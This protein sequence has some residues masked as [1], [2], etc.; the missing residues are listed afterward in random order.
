M[1][2]GMRVGS[3]L[4]A[5]RKNAGISLDEIAKRTKVNVSKLVALEKADFK[6][7]PTGFYLFSM[8]RAYAGEVH[9]DP[10]PI[11]ERL[12]A[13]FAEK[14]ALD[15]LHTL[16]ATGAL[17][18]KQLGNARKSPEERSS[19]FRIVAAAFGVALIAAAGT[20]AY[21]HRRNGTPPEEVRSTNVET[22]SV[23]LP[24]PATTDAVAVHPPA[25]TKNQRPK[26]RMAARRPAPEGTVA[27]SSDASDASSPGPE[28]TEEPADKPADVEEVS[29]AP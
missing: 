17:T 26:P 12:R 23:P 6:N 9:I 1:P 20:G 13:E 16:D 19:L 8:V 24:A 3:D 10:E 21:L 22:A 4:K 25:S 7:L 5:A 28:R 15:A 11:V 14:D 2:V 29:P 18:S 27:T